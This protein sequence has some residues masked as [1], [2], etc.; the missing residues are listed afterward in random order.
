MSQKQLASS[1][2]GCSIACAGIY[3]TNELHMSE[4]VTKDMVAT[5]WK[6]LWQEEHHTQQA[7]SN[8]CMKDESWSTSKCPVLTVLATSLIH[9]RVLS[10][11]QINFTCRKSRKHVLATRWQPFLARRKSYPA[12][13]FQ[14]FDSPS[15]CASKLGFW[16][17]PVS[18]VK[19]EEE[20]NSKKSTYR[21]VGLA[22]SF[23]GSS[24]SAEGT[25]NKIVVNAIGSS[26]ISETSSGHRNSIFAWKM[27]PQVSVSKLGSSET[28]YWPT[29]V[30]GVKPEEENENVT[31][32]CEEQKTHIT[33]VYGWEASGPRKQRPL[34]NWSILV[35]PCWQA[36]WH[37]SLQLP[38]NGELHIWTWNAML[39]SKVPKNAS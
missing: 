6:P 20:N 30:S 36:P 3:N 33:Y 9:R 28:K 13:K 29:P 27:M 10:A 19:P 26:F 16:R 21:E 15:L 22:S 37:A 4:H 25:C 24:M 18:G 35:S 5:H 39:G 12:S 2:G 23:C 7:I 14:S 17:T 8:L 32:W 31:E 38:W 1:I 34:Y 11:K